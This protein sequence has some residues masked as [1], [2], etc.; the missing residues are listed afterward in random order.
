MRKILLQWFCRGS[1]LPFLDVLVMKEGGRLLTSVYHKPSHTERY[2]PY[3]SHHH[4]RTVTGVLRCM[5]DR[6]CNICY[7][8]KMQQDLDHLN[9]VF[10]ANGFPETLVKMTLTTDPFPFPAASVPQQNS[11]SKILCT[12]YI[13]RLSEKIEIYAPIGNEACLQTNEHS[14][15]RPNATKNKTP[16]Q[17]ETR[18]V[19]EVPCKDCPGGVLG[20]S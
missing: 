1:L 17:K 7:P 5:R 9:Q 12:P 6:A 13:K 4:P 15:K 3:H 11:T 10:Q 2:I 20:W 16:E 8:T 18:V 19:Y 14:E